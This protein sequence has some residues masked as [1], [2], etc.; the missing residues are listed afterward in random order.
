VP[1]SV[2]ILA[3]LDFSLEQRPVYIPIAREVMVNEAPLWSRLP[4]KPA[5]GQT[6]TI[7][8]YGVRGRNY[9]VGTG[10]IASGATSL[11]LADASPFMVGDVLGIRPAAG[12]AEE[13]V[14]V[15]QPPALGTTPNTLTVRRAR[16]STTAATFAAGDTIRLI[17]NSRQGTEIDQQASRTNI[18]QVTQIVQTFQEPVQVGGLANAIS[19]VVL[20]A[21]ASDLFGQSKATKL[22]ETIR[23]IEYTFYYGK[24][25]VPAASGDRAKTR[26]I[27]ELIS[28]WNGGS[29]VR[30]GTAISSYTRQ[31]FIADTVAK[32]WAAGGLADV[33]MC[34][35][36][37]MGILDTW[38]P[39][40]SAQMGS[41]NTSQLGFPI[42]TFVLPLQGNPLTFIPCPQ[43]E[44]GTAFVTSSN[45]LEIRTIRELFFNPREVRGDAIEGEWLGDY[46]PHINRPQWHAWVDSIASAA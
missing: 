3:P 2:G 16:S 37:F 21:G 40:K 26:G 32:I 43:F 34:S 22:V 31:Q 12:G 45:D 6:Y 36:D 1:N 33:I 4:H 11:P 24:G 35:L 9:V 13:R 42:T 7:N 19:N 18:T 27:R 39:S 41:G 38:V 46:A 17:G 28:L 29:N 30:S 5:G 15:L 8:T 14:E 44:P 23:D 10:G 20:P 25:E